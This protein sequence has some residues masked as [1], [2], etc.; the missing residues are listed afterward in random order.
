MKIETFTD[1]FD[2]ITNMPDTEGRDGIHISAQLRVDAMQMENHRMSWVS[3][4]METAARRIDA[5][6]D[7]RFGPAAAQQAGKGTRRERCLPSMD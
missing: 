6:E 1:P 5:L 4:T 2:V 7:G 3:R